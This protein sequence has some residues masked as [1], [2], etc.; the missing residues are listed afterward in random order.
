MPGSLTLSDMIAQLFGIRTTS[1]ENPLVDEVGVAVTRLLPMNPRRVGLVIINLSANNVYIAP[2][3]QVGADHGIW[4][5]PN[6][7]SIS[8]VW[9]RDFELCTLEWFGLAAA[10]NSDI[11]VLE[12]TISA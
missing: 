5:V 7:G 3:N 6:G 2:S 10:A 1:N 9:D 4:L 11:Y 8:L 12:Y